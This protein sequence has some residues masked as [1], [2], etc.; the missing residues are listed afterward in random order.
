M[1][2]SIL[3]TQKYVCFLCG[4][5]GPTECHHIFGGPNRRLSDEDGLFVHL[6][7][8][9]HNQP[10][11]GAHFNKETAKKLHMVGQKAWEAKYGD[12]ADFM[13]RYGKNFM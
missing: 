1:K 8:S 9:C 11:D 2:Q 7:H 13:R 12:R 4:R 10:P 3:D 5:I 6:C